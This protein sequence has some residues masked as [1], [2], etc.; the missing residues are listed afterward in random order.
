MFELL[1][2]NGAEVDAKD[3]HNM[4]PLIVSAAACKKWRDRYVAEILISY[5]AD[6][7][8]SDD[9]GRTPLHAAAEMLNKYFA[10]MLIIH[11]A[12]VNARNRKGKTPLFYTDYK[13]WDQ[14]AVTEPVK[15][16]SS[17]DSMMNW[18][19]EASDMAELLKRF[20]AVE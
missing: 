8:A 7:N 14:R 16:G 2:L 15:L 6:V 17:N 19:V 4:T 5:G 9:M 12:N 18:I 11:G 20:G 13:N 1:I 10:E 3:N